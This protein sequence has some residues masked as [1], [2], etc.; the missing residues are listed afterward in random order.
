[1]SIKIRENVQLRLGVVFFWNLISSV[2]IKETVITVVTEQN[3]AGIFSFGNIEYNGRYS[4]KT[5]IAPK[6]KISVHDNP[7]LYTFQLFAKQTF[8][9]CYETVSS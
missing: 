2:R 5:V 8:T 1:M 4:R 3:Q 7:R 9:H 6:A